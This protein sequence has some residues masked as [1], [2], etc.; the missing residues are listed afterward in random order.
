M[1]LPFY[2]NLIAIYAIYVYINGPDGINAD[3]KPIVIESRMMKKTECKQL[4]CT[5]ARFGAALTNTTE[6]QQV[7]QNLYSVYLHH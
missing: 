2:D 1:S 3:T 7:I 6:I 5:N 4:D